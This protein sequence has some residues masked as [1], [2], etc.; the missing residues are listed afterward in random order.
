MGVSIEIYRAEIGHFNCYKLL[1]RC[2]CISFAFFWTP[3]VCLH[4]GI[5][6]ALFFLS[7]SDVEI[8]PGPG[9]SL[10]LKLGHLNVRSLNVVDKFEEIALIILN[11]DFKIFALSETWLNSLIPSELFDIPGYCSLYRR[12]R[13]DG[14]RAGGVGLYVSLDFVPKR[15]RDL[16]TIDFELLWV[17]IKINS[18]NMLCGVCYRPRGL[19]TDMNVA[20]LDNLQMCLDKV[21]SKPDTLVVL[22]G[23]FK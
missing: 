21:L 1:S 17:E 5:L 18:I 7:C 14:R 6:L 20:F 22:L 9:R 3:L 19:S 2:F 15:R 12:D 23:D 4:F 11:E 13:L 16:E 8:N 10:F